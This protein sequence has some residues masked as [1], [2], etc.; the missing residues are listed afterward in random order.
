MKNRVEKQVSASKANRFTELEGLRAIAAAIVVFYHAALIFYPGFFYGVGNSW[1]P[2]QNMRFEDNL[3]QHPLAGLMS[4]TFAVGIFFV[5]SGFVL[6]IGYFKKKDSSVISKLAAKRYLRLMVPAAASVMIAWA[7]MT[8]GWS[9]SMNEVSAVTHSGWLSH[10]WNVSP[11]FFRALYQGTVASFTAGEVYYNP[12]L[13]TISQEFIGS[14]LVFGVALLFSSSKYRWVV[15]GVLLYV[16]SN[17]WLLGFITGMILAD[18]Y[19]HKE[20][21]FKKLNSKWTYLLLLVGV[22][23]G[24]FPSGELSSPLYKLMEIPKFTLGQQLAFHITWGATFVVMSVLA[25]PRLRNFMAHPMISRFGK[26]TYSLYLIHMPVLFTVCTG[27]FL[28]ALPIGFNKAA[29]IAV[30]ATWAVL[31]PAVYLFERYVDAPAIRLAGYSTDI[32]LGKKELHARKKLLV[33]KRYVTKK[34]K[35]LN[36]RRTTEAMSEVEVE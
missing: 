20:V 11:D 18:L 17:G 7:V 26:Y 34:M 12:V 14:F 3:Y 24:G 9:R 31:I 22:V 5:L 8:L 30:V 4:G 21:V 29:V 28:L 15:Y 36:P 13:W 1:A 19:V 33:V 6:S 23:L 25:L 35:S 2:V 27:T 10:L 32:F 16:L